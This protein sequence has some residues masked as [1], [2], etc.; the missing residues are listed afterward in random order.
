MP[1]VWS[2]VWAESLATTFC[3]RLAMKLRGPRTAPYIQSRRQRAERAT[4]F[5]TSGPRGSFAV[6]GQCTCLVPE[7]GA[8]TANFIKSYS[9]LRLS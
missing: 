5:Q 9:H 3:P 2:E 7:P 4:R 8:P 1:F 6:M